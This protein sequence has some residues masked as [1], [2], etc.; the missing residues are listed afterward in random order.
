MLFEGL[1]FSRLL[2]NNIYVC[3]ILICTIQFLMKMPC[4]CSDQYSVCYLPI[5]CKNTVLLH[6]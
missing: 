2:E 3:K 6:L 4:N 5:K 1:M